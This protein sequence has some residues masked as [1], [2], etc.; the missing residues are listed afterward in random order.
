MLI[1]TERTLQWA[2][3][4]ETIFEQHI[5]PPVNLWGDLLFKFYSCAGVCGVCIKNLKHLFLSGCCF[6]NVTWFGLNFQK[7]KAGK[8]SETLKELVNVT[9]KMFV[10]LELNLPPSIF[11]CSPQNKLLKWLLFLWTENFSKI[12]CYLVGKIGS[13]TLE[14]LIQ[15]SPFLRT[16]NHPQRVHFLS[17]YI[18]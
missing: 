1:G 3:V 7:R 14:H 6:S 17:P 16:N 2:I 4:C 10:F 11:I 5:Q 18:F 12:V 9:F 8:H 15:L 13:P